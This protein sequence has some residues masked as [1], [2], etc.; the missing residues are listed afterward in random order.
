MME[1]WRRLNLFSDPL[2]LMRPSVKSWIRRWQGF[3]AAELFGN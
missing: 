3:S 1:A 2:S